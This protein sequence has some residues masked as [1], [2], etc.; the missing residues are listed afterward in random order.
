MAARNFR[1]QFCFVEWT[2]GDDG[3]QRYV[4]TKCHGTGVMRFKE[5]MGF[6]QGTPEYQRS[7]PCNECN[8]QGGGVRPTFLLLRVIHVVQN[9]CYDKGEKDC[10]TLNFRNYPLRI[11]P[12]G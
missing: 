2:L 5:T 9:A 3:M 1:C 12:N 7:A 6:E 10:I 11:V 8:G 4:C